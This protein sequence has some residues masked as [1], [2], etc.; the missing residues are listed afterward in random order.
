MAI[1]Q[2]FQGYAGEIREEGATGIEEEAVAFEVDIVQP[3][4]PNLIRVDTPPSTVS[5]LLDRIK[6]DEVDLLPDFQRKAGIWSDSAQSR[7]IESLLIRIPLPAFYFDASNEDRWVIVDGLQRTTALKRFVIDRSLRLCGMDYLKSLNGLTFDEL[8]RNLQR[9]VVETPI[10]VYLI[11]KGT[12]PEAKFNIFKRINTG[13]LPLSAQEIRHALN[14]GPATK[15]L[16]E[17]ASSEQFLAATDRCITDNRMADREC[18]LRFFAFWLTP[19]DRYTKDYD[20]YLIDCMILLNA[21]DDSVLENLKQIFLRSMQAA[22]DVF[23]KDAFRKKFDKT[24]SRSPINKALFESWSV[25]LAR[26]SDS[27]LAIVI[28]HKEDL[29]DRYIQLLK[30][31]TKFVESISLGTGDVKRIKKRFSSIEQ[32][33]AATVNEAQHARNAPS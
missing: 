28:A 29:V 19:Y 18:V 12:P 25:S 23:G 20:K 33:I 8:P 14:Q 17:L 4:D 24:D 16:V 32:L 10:I 21:L 13:G 9:R 11:A 22:R 31:D 26:L 5:L 15:M 30:T 7:L 1:S 27:E 2:V 3:F 6:N